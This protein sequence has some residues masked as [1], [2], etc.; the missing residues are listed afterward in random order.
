LTYLGVVYDSEAVIRCVLKLAH[1]FPKLDQNL[2]FQS[3]VQ[4]QH[5]FVATVTDLDNGRQ[6]SLIAEDNIAVLRESP[7]EL[8]RN[9]STSIGKDVTL[10]GDVVD[11]F[12]ALRWQRKRSFGA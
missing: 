6:V 10:R 5:T 9:E 12:T 8:R 4:S 11:I 7:H 3:R 1:G 2:S